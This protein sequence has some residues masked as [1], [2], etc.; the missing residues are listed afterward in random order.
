ME[1]GLA[2]STIL[3]WRK[4]LAGSHSAGEGR[5]QV[6]RHDSRRFW[7][8]LDRCQVVGTRL[9]IRNAKKLCE[10]IAA[11]DLQSHPASTRMTP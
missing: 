2:V 4:G 9:H 1:R 7:V 8:I 10:S 11:L 6:R 5:F 3:C